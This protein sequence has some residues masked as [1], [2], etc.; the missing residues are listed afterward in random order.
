MEA[1]AKKRKAEEEELDGASNVKLVRLEDGS[2]IGPQLVRL[3]DIVVEDESGV[4]D[5]S[6]MLMEDDSVTN[7]KTQEC[8]L[9]A[10]QALNILSGSS[11][12]NEIIITLPDNV[13]LNSEGVVS[14]NTVGSVDQPSI[15]MESSEESTAANVMDPMEEQ[16]SVIQGYTVEDV[17]NEKISKDTNT[18]TEVINMAGTVEQSVS[19]VHNQISAEHAVIQEQPTIDMTPNVQIVGTEDNVILVNT[20]SH[21]RA[22]DQTQMM[23]IKS[24]NKNEAAPVRLIHNI[25]TEDVGVEARED[26]EE[27][28]GGFQVVAEWSSSAEQQQQQQVDTIRYLIN[29][30]WSTHI[31]LFIIYSYNIHGTVYNI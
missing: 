5:A 23:S 22:H 28:E 12:G 9:Q 31:V 21:V 2:G 14:M 16:Y 1:A 27:E 24:E 13:H 15:V 6:S 18:A 10:E 8:M 20:E 11:N 29:F 17:T 19:S 3:S 7:D 25:H 26:D 4:T 30:R